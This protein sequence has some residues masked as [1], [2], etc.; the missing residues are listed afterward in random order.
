MKAYTDI[1]QSKKLA[2]Y[3][4]RQGD[5]NTRTFHQ[6]RGRE[7]HHGERETRYGYEQDE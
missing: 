1:E 6:R 3:R 7:T 5:S 4:R 2:G